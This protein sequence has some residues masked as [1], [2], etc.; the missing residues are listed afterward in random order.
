MFNILIQ[1]RQIAIIQF[2]HLSTTTDNFLSHIG[3]LAAKRLRP[4][5][6]DN[7]QNLF[8]NT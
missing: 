2:L 4:Q 6:T 7:K 1:Q 5:R 8:H 3:H